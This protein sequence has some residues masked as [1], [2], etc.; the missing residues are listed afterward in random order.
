[1]SGHRGEREHEI[2]GVTNR[3]AVA[4]G[5]TALAGVGL[6]VVYLQ[7]GQVQLEGALLGVA[8]GALG[9]G[10]VMVGRRLLPQGPYTEERDR[11]VATPE[12]RAAFE[13]DMERGG[14]WLARRGFLVKMLAVAGGALGLA[15][16][17]PLRSLGPNPGN[18]LRTT[19]W[20]K[21]SRVVDEQGDPVGVDTLAEGGILTVFPEGYLED[22]ESQTLLIRY[23]EDKF[24]ILDGREDWVTN[25]YVAYSKVCTHAGCP[26]GLYQRDTGDLLCP[27]HQSTF[28]VNDG[29]RPIFGPAATP[30]PQLAIEVD[31]DGYLVAQG[32]YD[33]PVGP[34]FWNRNR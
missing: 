2:R 25:N 27:C 15:A 31:D 13:E 26:V 21:G 7:G 4:F 33:E 16:I 19:R 29:A 11:L 1:M 3:V 5:L 30:L 18:T 10:F 20:R 9:Y 6:F 8:L 17:L 28:D 23:D 32:D 12:E 34:G 14:P 24:E 22:E